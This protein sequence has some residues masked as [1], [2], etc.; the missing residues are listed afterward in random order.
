M[1]KVYFS[2]DKAKI[3]FAVNVGDSVKNISFSNFGGSFSSFDEKEQDAIERSYYFKKGLIFLSEKANQSKKFE[4]K[5][6][7]SKEYPEITDLNDAVSI[8]RGDPYK[9]HYSK[10]KNKDAIFSIANDV[11]VSFPNL[12]KD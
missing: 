3:V 10:L 2:K 6:L 5:K 1:D 8:L 4:E 12:P 11:G 7:D 9:I